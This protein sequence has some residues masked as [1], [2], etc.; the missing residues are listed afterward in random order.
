MADLDLGALARDVAELYEPVAEDKGLSLTLVCGDGLTVKGNR[1]L[2]SQALANLVD[3]A[4]KYTPGSGAVV[5]TARDA[6][7]TVEVAVAD[8]GPGIP[9]GERDR[10]LDR[11]V[12]L[13]SSRRSP[14]SGLG[15]SLVAAVARLH[16]AGLTLEDNRPGL[17]AVMRFPTRPAD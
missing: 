11:F 17:R 7:G 4:I 8:T 3:N 14:G 5:V 6:S 10:V 13:E 15:L 2:L 1:H 9:E 16:G 12:R